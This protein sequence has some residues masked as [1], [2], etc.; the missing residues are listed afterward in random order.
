MRWWLPM[1]VVRLAL[2]AAAA[3]VAVA[4]C[5]GVGEGAPPRGVALPIPAA[6]YVR[7]MPGCVWGTGAKTLTITRHVGQAFNL[8][9]LSSSPRLLQQ[10]GGAAAPLPS[11]AIGHHQAVALVWNVPSTV[12]LTTCAGTV[13]LTVKVGAKPSG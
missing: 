11:N 3:V 4:A 1:K 8:V 10:A 9:N 7:V 13:K 12:V 2:V 5:P 6:P